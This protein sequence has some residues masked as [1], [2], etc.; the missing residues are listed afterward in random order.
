MDVGDLAVDQ[1][2]DQYVGALTDSLGH[3]EDLMTLRM[4]PPATSDRAARDRL[5]KAWDRPSRSLEHDSVTLDECQS[6]FRSHITP[7][8]QTVHLSAELLILQPS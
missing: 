4:A 2:A 1:L 5:R 6:L 3:T 7:V 8:A